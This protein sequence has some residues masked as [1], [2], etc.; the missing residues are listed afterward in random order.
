MSIIYIPRHP[1]STKIR[2]FTTIPDSLKEKIPEKDWTKT[3]NEINAII[4]FSTRI[5]FLTVLAHVFIIPVCFM[6]NKKM[7]DNLYKYLKYKNM[8]MLKYGLY[9]CHPVVSK[10][11]ELRIIIDDESYEF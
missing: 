4:D 10:Y 8:S 3:I 9:I 1:T 11:N 2:Y 7:E 5:D 6:N